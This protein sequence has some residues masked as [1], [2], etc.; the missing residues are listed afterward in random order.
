MWV[1]V[2][3]RTGSDVVLRITLFGEVGNALQVFKWVSIGLFLRVATE[4]TKGILLAAPRPT[5]VGFL[6]PREAPSICTLPSLLV[7]IA[8]AHDLHQL[9]VPNLG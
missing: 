8:L 2:P 5:F 4:M 9:L 7:G 3:S 1:G 6:P